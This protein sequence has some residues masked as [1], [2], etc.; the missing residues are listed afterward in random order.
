MLLS[1]CNATPSSKKSGT[2]TTNAPRAIPTSAIDATT[3]NQGDTQLQTFAQWIAQMK[4]FGGNVATYQ[5][6]YTTDQQALQ[7]ASTKTTYET[8]LTALNGHVAA[9]QLPT[10]KTEAHSLQQ[11]LQQQATDWGTQ[12]QYHDADDNTNYPLAYGYGVDGDAGNMQ[13]D[14]NAAQTT[15]DYQQAIESL[16]TYLTNFQAMKTNSTDKT[17]YNQVHQTDMQLMQH[18]GKTHGKVLVVSLEEQ[19]L[20]VYDNGNLV[21]SLLVTTGKPGHPSLPGSWWIEDKL[22]PTVFKSGAKPGSPDYYPDT[23][24]HFAM[25]YHSNVYFF[26]DSWWRSLYGPNTNFPHLDTGG[27]SAAA[28]GSHGCVN[29]SLDDATWL[30]SFVSINTTSAILY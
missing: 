4:Q 14:I 11:Q 18:Y 23:P 22:S 7:H 16:Q 17:P 19:A 28:F 26:H 2:S 30:Y 5:Q 1:A 9:I 20:R 6:Q 3:K 15:A 12:H 10:M 27:D 13:D 25:Q 29:V 24:I 21:K 8:A